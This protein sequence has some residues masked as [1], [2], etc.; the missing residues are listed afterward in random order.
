MTHLNIYNISYGKKKGHES[1]WQF[2]SRPRNVKNRPNFHACRWRATHRWKDL[3]E[4]YNFVL[5]FVPIRGLSIMLQPRKIARIPTLAIS[6]LPFESPKTKSHLD[7]A[8]MERC[9]IYYMGESGGFP[10]VRAVLSLVSPKSPVACLS[11]KGA[12]TQY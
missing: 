5:S 9:K 7:V 11:T 12:L 8:L 3:D 2:D 4:S 6:G 10:Q 1:N